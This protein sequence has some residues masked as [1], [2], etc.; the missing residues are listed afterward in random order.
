[1]CAPSPLSFGEVD[2]A[3][4]LQ[5]ARLRYDGMDVLKVD[6]HLLARMLP[7]LPPQGVAGSLDLIPLI[8]GFTRGALLDPSLVRLPNEEGDDSWAC[9]RMRLEEDHEM[10]PLLT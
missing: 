1:M 2:W 8:G 10:A 9:A 5:R 3:R 6:G 4:E 7:T